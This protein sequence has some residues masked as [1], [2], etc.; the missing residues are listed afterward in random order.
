MDVRWGEMDALR[1]VNNVAYFRYFE[2]ARVRLFYAM[3]LF[4]SHGR[5]GVLAHAS[6]DFLRPLMYP[7]CIVVGL[8]RVRLGRSS[9]ELECWISDAD[10]PGIVHARGRNV[11]V[12]IDGRTGRPVPWTETER[13]ALD[14]CFST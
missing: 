3:G 4:G 9:L 1:H 6:C 14:R 12:C 11:L 13:Q 8:K 2:E 7:A 5:D 10:D